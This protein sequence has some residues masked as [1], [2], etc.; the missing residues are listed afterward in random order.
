MTTN[1]IQQP[2]LLR[3]GVELL[4]G[5]DVEQDSQKRIDLS[6][7]VIELDVYG[8]HFL[9]TH[10]LAIGIPLCG[11]NRTLALAHQLGPDKVPVIGAQLLPC[12]LL[13]SSTLDRYAVGGP[14]ESPR[15]TVLPLAHLRVALCSNQLAHTTDGH[16]AVG[17]E[18]LGKI[19]E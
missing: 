5:F 17:I 19:H 18:V 2:L 4:L 3:Q 12:N 16:G 6:D 11:D 13:V 7:V 14:R 1:Q 15:V 9:S 10:H 8:R